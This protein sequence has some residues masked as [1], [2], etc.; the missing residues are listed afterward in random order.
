MINA[1]RL[2]RKVNGV[3]KSMKQRAPDIVFNCWEAA[4]IVC[5][6]SERRAKLISEANTQTGK[7]D[8]DTITLLL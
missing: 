4:R 2:D 1:V 3:G 5:D 6:V 7:A 8:P